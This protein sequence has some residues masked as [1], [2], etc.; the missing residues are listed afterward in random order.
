MLVLLALC[1]SPRKGNTSLIIGIQPLGTVNTA[2]IDTVTN[3]LKRTYGARIYVLPERQMPKDAFINVKTPRY[4]ADKLIRM[5]RDEKPDSLDH[6][7]ALTQT[8]IS[9]TR[10]DAS[11]QTQKPESKYADWGV[12]GYGYR[13]GASCIVSTQRLKTPDKAKQML[14]LKKVAIHEIGHNLGL[15]HCTSLHCVMRDAA[16]TI[17]N[18]RCRRG[19][20]V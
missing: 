13:P 9:I 7:L 1:C 14:R 2:V 6:I 5:L 3:A 4:R 8:D 11:G 12:F 16:E 17:T 10:T 19:Y 20:T 15:D 18:D